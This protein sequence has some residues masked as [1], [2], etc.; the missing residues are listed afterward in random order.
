MEEPV[1]F[2]PPLPNRMIV[3]AKQITNTD[4]HIQNGQADTHL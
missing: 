2:M 4:V 3:F 1:Y